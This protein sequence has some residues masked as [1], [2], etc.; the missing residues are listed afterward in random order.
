MGDTVRRE[1]NAKHAV[2]VLPK[3]KKK[4]LNSNRKLNNMAY[5]SEQVG[6]IRVSK[7]MFESTLVISDKII[8]N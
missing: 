2:P 5:F 1:F 8:R 7:K 4:T 3:Y 6:K